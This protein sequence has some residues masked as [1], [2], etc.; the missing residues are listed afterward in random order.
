LP[1]LTTGSANIGYGD[2]F[3]WNSATLKAFRK[4]AYANAPAV[5]VV[6]TGTNIYTV[7]KFIGGWSSLGNSSSG[8]TMAG[9]IT[10]WAGSVLPAGA[11]WCDGAS[12]NRTAYPA[13]F[14][15]IGTAYGTASGTTFN[16][17][18][19]RGVILRGVDGTAGRDPDKAAR[20]ALNA[21]GNTGNN[22]GSYQSDAFQG[23][24]HNVYGDNAAGGLT[25]GLIRP[26]IFV[27]PTMTSANTAREPI[28]DGANGVPRTSNETRPKNVNVNY[29]IWI[30]DQ[31]ASNAAEYKMFSSSAPPASGYLRQ[32]TGPYSSATY[33]A[34]ATVMPGTTNAITNTG[35]GQAPLVA[36]KTGSNT[37][38]VFNANNYGFTTNGG[39]NWTTV[40]H[41][42]SVS[43]QGDANQNFAFFPTYG[44]NAVGVLVDLS[45]PATF[46]KRNLND[47][48]G[49]ACTA[50]GASVFLV[51]SVGAGQRNIVQRSIDNFATRAN[52]TLPANFLSSDASGA[53]IRGHYLTN[54]V[55]AV[56]DNT[57]SSIIAR[58][59]N[60]GDS[61]VAN[62]A[63]TFA[64]VNLPSAQI[65]S[66][67]A[68]NGTGKWLL[69]PIA[70][71]SGFVSNDDGVTW[72]QFT[73]PSPSESFYISGWDGLR[74]IMTSS[75][76]T[77]F[78][79]STTG[80]TGSW[81]NKSLSP[82]TIFGNSFRCNPARMTDNSL[83]IPTTAFHTLVNTNVT[84]NFF[85]V[86][87][88]TEPTGSQLWVVAS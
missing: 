75:N 37:M 72:T 20:V 39:A 57:S 81:V 66:A 54:T 71:S 58:S 42:E 31:S 24:W 22:V 35:Q 38:V 2:I 55:I 82:Y 70:G 26:G 46:V 63:A 23:H 7:A 80:A 41:S 64:Q 77:S 36:A 6:G 17:P 60:A 73:S 16:V 88:I 76:R 15:R 21:G 32:G 67:I 59:T 83:W 29:I 40:I 43:Y 87:A 68:T 65:I 69:A 14:A 78:W 48:L 9:E 33:P 56:R 27:N 62:G 85:T 52:I 10:A 61:A 28:N 8:S 53:L 13:L 19:L 51:N 50:A 30:N 4:Y 49:Y 34:L 18:D 84:S 12:Y 11:L 45:N 5:I 86:P 74:W 47:T 1:A 25:S 44:G 3:Y 79:Y